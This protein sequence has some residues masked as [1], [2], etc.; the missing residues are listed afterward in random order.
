MHGVRPDFPVLMVE[1]RAC[2]GE[3]VLRN[4]GSYTGSQDA[5][6]SPDSGADAAQ[7]KQRN[8]FEPKGT[9]EIVRTT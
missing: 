6:P 1:S 9:H 3:S 7:A 4:D 2:E 5:S 8:T